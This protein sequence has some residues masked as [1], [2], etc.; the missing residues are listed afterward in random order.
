MAKVYILPSNHSSALE[1]DV[2]RE[3][4]SQLRQHHR[5]LGIA[6]EVDTTEQS[7]KFLSNIAN[8]DNASMERVSRNAT[9]QSAF[10]ELLYA[11]K[12]NAFAGSPSYPIDIDGAGE[13]AV[14]IDNYREGLRMHAADL[15]EM[16]PIRERIGHAIGFLKCARDYDAFRNETML[17]N[18]KGI[19]V[20]KDHD[21]LLVA[22]GAVHAVY[23]RGELCNEGYDTRML[24]GMNYGANIVYA[25]TVID[26]EEATL[27]L[28]DPSECDPES[29]LKIARFVAAFDFGMEVL[30]Q[31]LA[32]HSAQEVEEF[33][34]SRMEEYYDS[35]PLMRGLGA[36]AD[37]D[38]HASAPRNGPSAQQKAA[39]RNL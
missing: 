13:S 31:V 12:D 1:P 27:A 5:S 23:L 22:V 19:L 36:A 39:N 35:Y 15:A 38:R 2:I 8:A 6:V 16:V 34:K 28:R 7:R 20:E 33:R 4:G 10:N 3:L 26:A 14:V 37:A 30:P 29:E 24:D 9:H 21:A 11:L 17:R 25:K 32:L 18:I